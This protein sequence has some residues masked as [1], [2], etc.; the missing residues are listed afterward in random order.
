MK[1]PKFALERKKAHGNITKE[2]IETGSWKDSEFKMNFKTLGKPVSGGYLHPLLKVRSEFRKILLSMG[3]M[4][5][6]IFKCL[7]NLV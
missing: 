7:I 4:M 5:L 1:G 2:M 3:Y 6:Y